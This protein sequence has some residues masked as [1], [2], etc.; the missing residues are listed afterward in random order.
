M[1]ALKQ[2]HEKT[3]FSRF[4]IDY[5]IEIITSSIFCLVC[6]VVVNTIYNI[7]SQSSTTKLEEK[8]QKSVKEL[9]IELTNTLNSFFEEL[10]SI[11]TELCKGKISNNEEEYLNGREGE[12]NGNQNKEILIQLEK[13]NNNV[14]SVIQT[15]R[16]S[17]L[18]NNEKDRYVEIIDK[19]RDF[20][21][22]S[23]PKQNDESVLLEASKCNEA[24]LKIIE[25]MNGVIELREKE[26]K[27]KNDKRNNELLSA[28]AIKQMTEPLIELMT[29]SNEKI[30]KILEDTLKEVAVLKNNNQSNQ[31]SENREQPAVTIVVPELEKI[32]ETLTNI[33]EKLS[34]GI[35]HEGVG[36]MVEG[37]VESNIYEK[38]RSLNNNKPQVLKNNTAFEEYKD[39]KIS[40]EE[41]I[42]K[43]TIF[44]EE[45][46]KKIFYCY[47][48]CTE[49]DFGNPFRRNIMYEK[50]LENMPNELYDDCEAIKKKLTRIYEFEP[51]FSI[52][53]LFIFFLE[54]YS[55]NNKFEED[56]DDE[57]DLNNEKNIPKEQRSFSSMPD[58]VKYVFY[59]ID[60]YMRNEVERMRTANAGKVVLAL[61]ELERATKTSN[62]KISASLREIS[63]AITQAI[64]NDREEKKNKKKKRKARERKKI[65]RERKKKMKNI[66]NIMA[67]RSAL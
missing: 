40:A 42:L 21:K 52:T 4:L 55:V 1:P 50:I 32:L 15:L 43:N 5:N 61:G 14:L 6:I 37:E 64:A 35:V 63:Q 9:V 17:L 60:K 36:R 67:T 27:P 23:L 54:Q 7:H 28:E 39:I 45:E 2:Y 31:K 58:F 20:L 56:G 25:R 53:D 26:E 38:K 24:S 3:A 11:N 8:N 19:L 22:E 44:T 41:N 33:V 10:S 47:N 62:Q 29:K 65:K 18:K 12:N 30:A 48:Y 49:V 16:D 51:D 46:M 66:S 57:E 34:S 13:Q 59:K